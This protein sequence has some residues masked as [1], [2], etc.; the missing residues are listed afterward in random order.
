M[1]IWFFSRHLRNG[2]FGGRYGFRDFRDRLIGSVLIGGLY[3]YDLVGFLCISRCCFGVG[4]LNA[5]FLAHSINIL[6]FSHLLF[7]NGIVVLRLILYGPMG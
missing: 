1:Y 2:F 6:A 4:P 7:G 3:S 5:L